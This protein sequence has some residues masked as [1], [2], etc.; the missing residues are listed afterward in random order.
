MELEVHEDFLAQYLAKGFDQVDVN[1]GSVVK[2]GTA[3]NF[4]SLQLAYVQLSEENKSLLTKN[5]QLIKQVE[6]LNK[7]IAELSKKSNEPSK[8]SS[9][10][11]TN[12]E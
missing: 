2:K 8:K 11:K 10:A 7:K 1:T 5:K 9:T 6:E 12:K 4:N 3:N